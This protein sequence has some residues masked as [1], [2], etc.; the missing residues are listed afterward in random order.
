M[1]TLQQVH[2]D[3]QFVINGFDKCDLDQGYLGD[4]WFLA[5]CVGILQAPKCFAKVV[6]TDQ[7]YG[8]DYAGIIYYLHDLF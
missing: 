8:D 1:S 5:A 7:D 6:P 3:P 2:K 4:C